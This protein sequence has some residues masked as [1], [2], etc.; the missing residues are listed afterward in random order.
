MIKVKVG[1][2]LLLAEAGQCL[3]DVLIK[4]GKKIEQPCGGRGTC[5][6]CRVLVDNEEQRACRYV[7]QSDVTVEL[8]EQGHV[9]SET[10]AEENGNMTEH[11]CF[12][13]DVGTTTLALALISLDEQ[14]VVQVETAANPQRMFGADII[15]RMDCCKK[16]GVEKLQEILIAELNQMRKEF[17]TE[18]FLDMY[19]AGNTT[20][21]HILNGVDPSP[22]GVAPYRPVFLK[23]QCKPAAALGLNG[24]RNITLLP[25]V[26]AF[27]GADLV[28]GMNYVGMPEKGVYYLLVD[29]GTNAEIILFSEEKILCT[30]AAAGPCFEGADISCGMSATEGAITSFSIDADKKSAFCTIGAMKPKGIC[31]T[32]LVD[33]IAE[34]VR[35]GVIDE[36]G[37]M[38]QGDYVITEGVTLLQSDVRQFQL[39]KS[40]VYSAICALMHTAGVSYE[41]IEKLYISG[42]FSAQMNVENAIKV[43]LLPQELR[44]RILPINNSSL[45]GTVKYACE[46]GALSDYIENALYVDLATNDFF[47]DLFI[48]NMEF[49]FR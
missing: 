11:L 29:L 17:Q 8:M 39:A 14:R 18:R 35:V 21:L 43:G 34:L 20:M 46:G 10:G 30:S 22:M 42:G 48:E 15:T 31:G 37:Y 41:Q 45:L 2:E 19:V 47:M 12:A 24:I 40:A 6:K 26:S 33:I 23:E 5:G 1:S 49:Y 16:Q 13:L 32:G 44:G 27:V 38:E 28:A 7:L 4:Y 25:S 9:V 3:A 36:T